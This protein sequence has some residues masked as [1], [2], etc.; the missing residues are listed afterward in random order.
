[1][2]FYT[3]LLV[4]VL[5]AFTVSACLQNA[6]ASWQRVPGIVCGDRLCSEVVACP[7]GQM[8]DT[9]YGNCQPG[10][11]GWKIT[12]YFLPL[13]RDYPR[14]KTVA[15]Y[16]SGSR[17]DGSFDY[18]ESAEKYYLKHFKETFL[19]EI[20]V[21][22]SGKTS[23]NRILQS[24]QDDFISP[25][26]IKTRFFHYGECPLTFTGACLPMTSSSLLEPVIMVA[27]THGKTNMTE[28]TIQHGTLLRIPDI[29]SPWNAR[30]YW[31]VDVGEW[32][33]KHIDIFTGYGLAAR[34]AA[35]KI[36]KLPPEEQSRVLAVGFK[37][38]TPQAQVTP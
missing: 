24:W 17:S 14:D 2:R 12:G 19:E 11:N 5:I 28:G 4:S 9:V 26:G 3:A 29:P 35:F 34:D 20:A 21:Q 1:M 7:S 32:R 16:V 15:A 36:T 37:E 27:V 22:G 13:E 23:D 18:E 33:D 30:T 31:A 6:D 8:R 25:D 38:I 10:S